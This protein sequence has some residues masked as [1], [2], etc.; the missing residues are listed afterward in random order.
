MAEFI[1]YRKVRSVIKHPN[2]DRLAIVQVGS[3]QVVHSLE[4]AEKFNLGQKVVHFPTDICIDPMEAEALHVS[5]YCR[6]VRYKDA[7]EKVSCR[8]VAARIRGIPSYGFILSD[9][10]I[11]DDKLDEYFGVWKY[12]PAPYMQAQNGLVER[13]SHPQFPKYTKITRMQLNPDAWAEGLPV[14]ITE[15]LHGANTRLG[16]VQVEGK[17]RFMVG[18]H[19]VILREHEN[20]NA[21]GD[22]KMGAPLRRNAYWS[23]LDSKVMHLLTL[24]S[25]EKKSVVVYGERIG[26]GVQDLDYGFDKPVLRVYDIK[27][28]GQYVSW[29]VLEH[30]CRM[31]G[32]QTVP[33]LDK[34]YFTWKLVEDMTNGLSYA[35]GDSL[36]CKSKFK[37]REGIV[38]TPLTEVFSEVLGDRLIGKS[39][40]CD[41]EARRGGTEYH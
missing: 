14:R 27:V 21:D 34:D 38:V 10:C 41:Y 3:F 26:R 4:E 6:K 24:L 13:E 36:T 37:G 31:T 33:L 25:E 16:I 5:N 22:V 40:S 15:K 1:A 18:S 7:G 11:E 20:I 17:W 35:F 32:V 8:I 28:D 39:I 9:C 2:A 30:Y 19:N 23:L 12:E 29:D